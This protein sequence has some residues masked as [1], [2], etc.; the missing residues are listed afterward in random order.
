M[1]NDRELRLLQAA[2]GKRDDSIRYWELLIKYS[3]NRIQLEQ[4]KIKQ[5]Q[6]KIQ[7]AR[8]KY[9]KILESQDII[10]LDSDD[11]II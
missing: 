7:L 8:E 3:E 5:Y 6:R 9:Q 2:R 1:N 11:E 10:D 4:S